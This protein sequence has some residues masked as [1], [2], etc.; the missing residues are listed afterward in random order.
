MKWFLPAGAQGERSTASCATA[1]TQLMAGACGSASAKSCPSQCKQRLAEE[2]QKG[3]SQDC[4]DDVVAAYK[5]LGG[6]AFQL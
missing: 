1:L 2:A 4:Y 6:T 5:M 3:I